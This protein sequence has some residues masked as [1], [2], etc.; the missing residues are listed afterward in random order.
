MENFSF[1]VRGFFFIIPRKRQ[2]VTKDAR[3][4][5]GGG[6]GEGEILLRRHFISFHELSPSPPLKW[7]ITATI[8]SSVRLAYKHFID[9]LIDVYFREFYLIFALCFSPLNA[10]IRS[11]AES[12]EH[13]KNKR[14]RFSM[15]ESEICSLSFRLSLRF[16]F[17]IRPPLSFVITKTD[18]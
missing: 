3:W 15:N 1:A 11:E 13:K 5:L 10:T 17:R 12:D 8:R 18:S 2:C 16:F 14:S 9:N 6:K 7:L 4:R